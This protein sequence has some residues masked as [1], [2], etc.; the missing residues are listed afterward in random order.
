[1]HSNLKNLIIFWNFL[2]TNIYDLFFIFLKNEYIK[3]YNYIIGFLVFIIIWF[4]SSQY[5]ID[6][7]HFQ[8][9]TLKSQRKIGYFLSIIVV[10]FHTIFY[11]GDF[12]HKITLFLNYGIFIYTYG[13][14][15]T[16]QGYS[17]TINDYYKTLSFYNISV[18]YIGSALLLITLYMKNLN[19][20]KKS[21]TKYI[22]TTLWFLAVYFIVDIVFKGLLS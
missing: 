8:D 14:I 9:L 2:K 3:N 22:K 19:N 5:F 7:F 18:M 17:I 21:C 12:N 15:I 6:L 20:S 10:C 16:E 4:F 11:R 13:L 1:M